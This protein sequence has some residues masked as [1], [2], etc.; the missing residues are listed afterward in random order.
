[1]T[2]ATLKTDTPDLLAKDAVRN[3]LIGELDRLKGLGSSVSRQQVAIVLGQWFHPLHYFPVF[4]SRLV[5]VSPDLEMQTNICRILWQELGE[6]DAERAHEKVYVDTMREVGF[7]P[8]DVANADP[9]GETEKLIEGYKRASADYL[10]GLGFL[11]GTE[12]ADLAMVSTIGK[13][14]RQCTSS[15]SLPWVDIHVQQEPGHVESSNKTLMPS[16]TE[17]DQTQIIQSAEEMWRLWAN[18]FRGVRQAVS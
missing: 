4:L 15:K 14:V 11:Y 9:L 5:S 3:E 12:V 6:G 17:A 10:P 8:R 16:F 7:N 18:F 1:M 13:L 2:S